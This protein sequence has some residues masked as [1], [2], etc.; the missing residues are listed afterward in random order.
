MHKMS[1]N[2][3]QS[4]ERDYKGNV[5]DLDIVYPFISEKQRKLLTNSDKRMLENIKSTP[6]FVGQRF[7]MS[8]E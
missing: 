4:L 5:I 7:A 2:E 1:D 3:F 6:G 8:W